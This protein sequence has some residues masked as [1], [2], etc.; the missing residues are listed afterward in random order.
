MY[1]AKVKE[2]LMKNP[3]KTPLE[4]SL[5]ANYE[6]NKAYFARKIKQREKALAEQRKWDAIRATRK[7][8]R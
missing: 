1:R 7:G 4:K 5:A 6:K 2:T 3:M 8:T